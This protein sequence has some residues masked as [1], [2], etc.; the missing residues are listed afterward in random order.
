[1]QCFGLLSTVAK[2]TIGET[3]HAMHHASNVARREL[4]LK[5][6]IRSSCQHVYQTDIFLDV[7]LA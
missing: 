2:N 4:I 7:Q 5:A 6:L 3:E 1:M